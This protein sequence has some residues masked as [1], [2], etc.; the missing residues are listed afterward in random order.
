VIESIKSK[1]MWPFNSFARR[2]AKTVVYLALLFTVPVIQCRE[3][4][5]IFIILLHPQY[6]IQ[7]QQEPSAVLTS[8]SGQMSSLAL[9]YPLP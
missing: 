8:V 3:E 1:Q 7:A 5:N 9:G 2:H 6:Q 4:Q